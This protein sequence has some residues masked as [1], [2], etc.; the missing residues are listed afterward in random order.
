MYRR[1]R[2]S[3]NIPPGVGVP[4]AKRYKKRGAACRNRVWFLNN[5][6]GVGVTSCSERNSVRVARGYRDCV[7]GVGG[8]RRRAPASRE[9]G[10]GDFFGNSLIDARVRLAVPCEILQ[11][12]AEWS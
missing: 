7:R 8:T 12:T 5:G 4:Y 10:G 6:V 9:V 3:K 2:L 1:K 11:V